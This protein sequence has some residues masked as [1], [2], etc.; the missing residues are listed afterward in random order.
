MSQLIIDEK[1][2]SQFD[3]SVDELPTKWT[4]GLF[5]GNGELGAMVYLNPEK[6]KLWW[7]LGK[8]DLQD[9]R[10]HE[11]NKDGLPDHETLHSWSWSCFHWTDPRLDL[12]AL[13]LSPVGEIISGSMRMHL[14]NAEVTGTIV[15][16]KGEIKFRSFTHSDHLV[17]VVELWTSE[18]E[19]GA[20]MAWH[21]FSA[22]APREQMRDYFAEYGGPKPLP[23]YQSNP[24][25]EVSEE[26]DWIYSTQKLLAGGDFGTA[27]CKQEIAP[28]HTRYYAST[29][30]LIPAEG[31]VKA[32]AA[33]VQKA[34]Q[35]DFTLLLSSHRTWWN[36]YFPLSGLDFPDERLLK[37]YWIQIYKLGGATRSDRSLIDNTGPWYKANA[38]AYVTWDMN[39]QLCY[40]PMYSGNRLCLA[41]SLRRYLE[42]T[43]E[44][45]IAAV[46]EKWQHD[47]AGNPGVS[48]QRVIGGEFAIL[49][50]LP[51]ALHNIWLEYRHSMDESL[52][53]DFLYPYLR[54]A[55]CYY[56]HLMFEGDDGFWHLP[57][58]FS[59]EY[60][61]RA[62]DTTFDLSLFR[63][64]CEKLLWANEHLGLDDELAGEWEEILEKLVPYHI[65]E[66]G[67]MI[68]KGVEYEVSHRHHQ[69]IMPFYPLHMD[70]WDQPEKREMIEKSVRHWLSLE[71]ELEGF[72]FTGGASHFALMRNAEE[73]LLWLNKLMDTQIH[74]NT[75]YTEWD[76]D[77]NPVI[78]TPLSVTVPLHEMMLQSWGDRLVIFPAVPADWKDTQFSQ[79]RGEGA[80]VVSATQE[81]GKTTF[82]E[83]HSEV[84]GRCRVETTLVNPTI[85]GLDSE[86]FSQIDGI[87][88][89]DLEPGERFTMRA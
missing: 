53:R 34:M 54:R 86:R 36:E 27:I 81:E 66:N 61:T 33:L 31:S 42:K 68:G 77:P 89:V 43:L 5:T 9:H 28:G 13:E 80:F 57:E 12:G 78:E 46:P 56:M 14:W 62:E 75:M 50:C 10:S 87:W 76:G 60:P 7:H 69:H 16:T 84:G 41:G 32:A 4:E 35:D 17:E 65:G 19:Q 63:W 25:A 83:V 67:Y 18:G 51:W 22:D 45:H 40:W 30:N 29:E 2:I 73:S 20:K 6:D 70:T 58:A 37:F 3:L 85:S 79:L 11:G 47:S 8:V 26:G 44:G 23:G 82:V 15:T 49:G 55:T 74:P 64:G 1:Y 72:S 39:L 88:Q 38:W 59:P 48:N 71:D 52:L 21:P 24:S